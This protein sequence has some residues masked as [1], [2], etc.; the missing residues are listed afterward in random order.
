[1]FITH[2][3]VQVIDVE[4]PTRQQGLDDGNYSGPSLAFDPE[5][6]AITRAFLPWFS[7]SEHQRPFPEEHDAR[8]LVVKEREWVHQHI[9]TNQDGEIPVADHQRFAM[10]AP[11]PGKEGADQ[12]RQ[13]K[14]CYRE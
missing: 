11:G 4:S 2:I 7:T 3:H 14:S 12:R 8:A 13:R 5:W 1:M 10:T 6:L 9:K